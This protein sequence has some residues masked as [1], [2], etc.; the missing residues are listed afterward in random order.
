MT[1]KNAQLAVRGNIILNYMVMMCVSENIPIPED[2]MD[3]KFLAHALNWKFADN[4]DHIKNETLRHAV[5]GTVVYDEIDTRQVNP[6]TRFVILDGNDDLLGNG[7]LVHN[8]VTI[9]TTN[10]RVAIAMESRH[11]QQHHIIQDY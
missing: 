9:F 2:F 11:Q 4:L 3:Q 6:I 1:I 5:A 10:I 7:W 8:L